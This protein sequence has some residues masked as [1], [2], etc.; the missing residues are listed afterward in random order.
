MMSTPS[1][2]WARI[3][4]YERVQL[5]AESEKAS[6]KDKINDLTSRISELNNS[7]RDRERCIQDLNRKLVGSLLLIKA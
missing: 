7:L 2:L 1:D 5:R 6:L 3:Q 4:D